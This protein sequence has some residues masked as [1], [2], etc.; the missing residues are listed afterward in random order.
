[1]G[2]KGAGP[3]ID[4]LRKNSETASQSRL[5]L[6]LWRV[7]DGCKFFGAPRI[8]RRGSCLVL[9]LWVVS[10]TEYKRHGAV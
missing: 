7:K 5:N 2:R 8:A 4:G 10:L 9:C 3:L 1:M 6:Q